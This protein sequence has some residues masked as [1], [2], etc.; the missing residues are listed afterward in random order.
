MRVSRNNRRHQVIRTKFLKLVYNSLLV[1]CNEN[2][3]NELKL[4]NFLYSAVTSSKMQILAQNSIT[5]YQMG[6][7]FVFKSLRLQKK[8]NLS[9]HFT[10][11]KVTIDRKKEER[12]P[13]SLN[14]MI[15]LIKIFAEVIVQWSTLWEKHALMFIFI[16]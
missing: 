1:I 12:L 6:T 14:I 15:L 8:T 10:T 4:L 2:E 9:K 13:P 5:K 11:S 7:K 16:N 3:L